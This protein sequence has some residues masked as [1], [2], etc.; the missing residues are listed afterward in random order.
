MGCSLFTLALVSQ[1]S[2][3]SADVT[4]TTYRPKFNS[5]S[6][7]NDATMNVI[8]NLTTTGGT[9]PTLDAKLQTSMDGTNWVD[10][11]SMTQLTGAGSRNERVALAFLG[12]YVRGVV[13]AGGTA[14]PDWTGYVYL[15]MDRPFTLST[16]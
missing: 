9:S 8:F 14:A 2:A 3:A 13:D 15:L 1:T 4:G 6:D 7:A 5:D 11:A 10:V 12:P 16:S